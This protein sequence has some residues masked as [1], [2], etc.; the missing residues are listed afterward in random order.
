MPAQQDEQKKP[1]RGGAAIFLATKAR[2][3]VAATARS[4]F[5]PVIFSRIA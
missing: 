3:F 5:Q 1:P 2:T 4:R